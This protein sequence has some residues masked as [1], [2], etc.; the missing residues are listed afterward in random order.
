MIFWIITGIWIAL[1]VFVFIYSGSTYRGSFDWVDASVSLVVTVT[2]GGLIWVVLSF[3]VLGAIAGA[4]AEAVNTGSDRDEL[5]AI[6]TDSSVS[7]RF[8]LGSG[9]ING[10]QTFSYLT[11]GE[12]GW[13]R[14]SSAEANASTVYESDETPYVEYFYWKDVPPWWVSPFVLFNKHEPVTYDF[15]VP[16]GSVLNNYQIQP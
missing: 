15:Y 16:E 5:A 14:L 8:F 12:D 4:N 13:F 1:I 3:P 2:L 6:A 9:Y 10:Y 11:K 7:G